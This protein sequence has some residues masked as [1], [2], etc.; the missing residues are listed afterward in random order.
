MNSAELLVIAIVAVIVF[1]PGKL[2][3]LAEHLGKLFRQ[4]NRFRDQASQFWQQ[5]MNEQQLKENERKAKE[6][7][8]VYQRE[9]E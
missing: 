2:P 9:K 4:F 7:D 3:M 8:S 1:G 5:Q 6:A